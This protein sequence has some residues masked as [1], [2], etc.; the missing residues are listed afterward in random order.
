MNNQCPKCEHQFLTINIWGFP[1]EHA[2]KRLK[3]EGHT[4]NVKG[5]IPPALDEEAFEF[6]CNQCGH[7]FGEYPDEDD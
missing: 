7:K 3:M 6:E 5:C 1:D 4:V 2:M